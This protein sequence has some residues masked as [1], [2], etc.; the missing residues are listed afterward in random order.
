MQHNHAGNTSPP[1]RRWRANIL[2]IA[3]L[4]IAG[5]YLV[6][7]QRAFLLAYWPLLLLLACPLLHIFM[8]RGHGHGGSGPSADREDDGTPPSAS[9]GHRH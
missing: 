2:L 6:A 3:V 5:F 7:E 1:T 4:I 8:H 9:G